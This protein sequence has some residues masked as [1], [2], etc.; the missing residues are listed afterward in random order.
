MSTI[1]E[2]SIE[3]S[4]IAT[5]CH[6]CVINQTRSACRFAELTEEQ[7]ERIIN[8]AKAGLEKSK[9]VPLLTQHIVRYVA[10]AI[11]QESEALPDF[12]IYAEVNN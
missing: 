8:V 6:P 2:S 9:K 10:D 3:E 1:I 4:S 12:D 5:D 7:T 11:I